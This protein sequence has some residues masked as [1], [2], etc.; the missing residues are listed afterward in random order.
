MVS[1]NDF[2]LTL[3]VDWAPDFAIDYVA[4]VLLENRVKA[5]WFITHQSEAIERLRENTELFELGIHPNISPGSTQGKTEDEVLAH[6]M[7]IVPGAISMR[8]HRLYQST[9]FLV[10]AATEY[11]ILIDVSLFL[12]RAACLQPHRLKWYGS[13][14]WRI[15]YFWEDDSEHFEDE[16]IWNLS[17]HRLNDSGLRVFDFHPIHI[18]LNTERFERYDNLKRVRPLKSWDGE[19]IEA[20][21]NRGKGPRSLFLELVHKL[22]GRGKRIKEIISDMEQ[23]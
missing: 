17:D 16:P 12:P 19:F 14:L 2:V 10:K 18:A 5:T 22:S 8:T 15:P 23:I 9:E 3:D 20:H 7:N 4:Q 21:I 6:V 13:S 1:K 11:G